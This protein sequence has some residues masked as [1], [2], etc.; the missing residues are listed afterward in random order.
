MFSLPLTLIA[1]LL[2]PRTAPSTGPAS[3]PA[4]ARQV[5]IDFRD[6]LKSGKLPTAR[7]MLQPIAT[8]VTPDELEQKFTRVAR[9]VAQPNCD[10]RVLDER[11]EGSVAVVAL[12]ESVKKPDGRVSRDV[13]PVFLVRRAGGWKILLDDPDQHGLDANELKASRN[14]QQWYAEREKTRRGNS[15]R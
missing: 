4:G 15:Q 5:M 3:A 13:D 12:E 6:A 11:T 1:L 2:A 9:L 14:L 7:A 8:P 10:W